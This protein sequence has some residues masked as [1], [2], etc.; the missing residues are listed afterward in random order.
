MSEEKYYRKSIV[1]TS[2]VHSRL[3]ALKDPEQT[4]NSV[5]ERLLESYERSGYTY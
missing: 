2:E 3:I 5:I 4:I 1:V